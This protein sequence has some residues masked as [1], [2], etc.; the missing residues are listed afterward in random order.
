[1][2]QLKVQMV[3]ITLFNLQ[4]LRISV[5]VNYRNDELNPK[6][7]DSERDRINQHRGHTI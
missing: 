3:A 5:I 6:E 7:K 4:M 1:M 2:V